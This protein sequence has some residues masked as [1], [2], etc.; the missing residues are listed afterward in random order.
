MAKKGTSS[1]KIIKG[2]GSG[3]NQHAAVVEITMLPLARCREIMNSGEVQYS[4][5]EVL[6]VRDYLYGLA[7]IASEQAAIKVDTKG[8]V[9]SLTEHKSKG[10]EEE[11]NHLRAG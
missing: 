5:E 1:L 8:K 9:I 2:N 6:K 3:Y 7:A 10:Y 11:S 4:D